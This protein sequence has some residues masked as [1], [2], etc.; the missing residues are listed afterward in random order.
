[1]DIRTEEK[2]QK[3]G[4]VSHIERNDQITNFPEKTNS[5]WLTVCVEYRTCVNISTIETTEKK[6][7][8]HD[9]DKTQTP[10]YIPTTINIYSLGNSNWDDVYILS[11]PNV[12]YVYKMAGGRPINSL[13]FCQSELSNNIMQQSLSFYLLLFLS[14]WCRP[15]QLARYIPFLSIMRCWRN[16]FGDLFLVSALRNACN[17]WWRYSIIWWIKESKSIAV[18]IPRNKNKQTK[19][20]HVIRVDIS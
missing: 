15:T 19:T 6:K 8:K 10:S 13:I 17:V 20:K 11:Y 4:R 16:I 12:G 14:P 1:M 9:D 5:L 18:A 7:G 2:G 3:G